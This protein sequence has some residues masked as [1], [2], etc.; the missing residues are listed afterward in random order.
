MGKMIEVKNIKKYFPLKKSLFFKKSYLK[1]VDDVSIDI[2]ERECL[3]IVGESGSGKSTLGK[4]ITQIYKPTSGKILYKNELITEKNDE[5]KQKFRRNVQAIFQDPYSSLDPTMTIYEIVAEAIRTKEDLNKDD[6]EIKIAD[7]LKKVGISKDFMRKKPREFSGGQRQRI[8][9]ARAISTNPEFILCDEPISALDV[10]IQAQII[11]LLED[12]KEELKVSYLFIAHDL[13]M[14]EHISDRIG[15]MYMGNLV[16]LGNKEEIFSNPKHPYTIGLLDSILTPY[17]RKD[18]QTK[19]K[20]IASEIQSPID[21][22]DMCMFYNRC[23][24]K[25]DICK[26]KKPELRKLE[27]GRSLACFNVK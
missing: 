7:L 2:S 3:G 23:P 15:V 27:K 8:S 13:A 14:V 11:N 6:M 10:S 1:A 12:L 17:P 21:T 26:S 16:E 4:L 20:S 25:T 5:V 19:L 18:K 9:I 22:K 24:Y